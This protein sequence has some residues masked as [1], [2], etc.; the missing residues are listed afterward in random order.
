[1]DKM[2]DGDRGTPC[3][4]LVVDDENDVLELVISHLSNKGICVKGMTSGKGLAEAIARDRPRL[5]LLDVVMPEFNGYTLCEAIKTGNGIDDTRVYFIS[6]L[7][8]EDVARHVERS[9]AAGFIA[10][11]FTFADIDAVLAAN[12]IGIAP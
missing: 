11:P 10:K 12:G 4:V 9:G 6:A 5:V 3:D 1:M 2:I 8:E 7:P